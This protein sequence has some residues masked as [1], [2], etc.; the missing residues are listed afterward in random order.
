M[1]KFNLA[2][3]AAVMAL[4]GAAAH[5]QQRLSPRLQPTT[6]R[7]AITTAPP[8]VVVV[9]PSQA[10]VSQLPKAPVAQAPRSTTP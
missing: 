4:G 6:Q 9:R 10:P 1:K 2:I 5:A 8:P 3:L 7:P